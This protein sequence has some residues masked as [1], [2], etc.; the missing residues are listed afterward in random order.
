ME[1]SAD[2]PLLY[3][4]ELIKGYD[5][6]SGSNFIDER[7]L[8]DVKAITSI[9]QYLL[10]ILFPGYSGTRDVTSDNLL[11]VIGDLTCTV[12]SD[13][14]TQISMAFRHNCHEKTCSYT[15]CDEKAAQAVEE[16]MRELPKIR[17]VLKKDVAAA[18][19]GDPAA[20]S[21]EEVVIC[22]PGIKALAI[23]R[24][25]HVLYQ[26]KVPLI[27][28]MMNEIAHAQTGIDIHPGARIGEGLFIDHGT[29]VVIGETTV[30]GSNVKIYQG[31]TL[32]ALSF[33]K[34]Q[35]GN[36][37]RGQKRHPTIQ[38]N[39]TIYAH[40][41]ILGN[42]TIQKSAVIGSNVWLKENVD[43][44]TVVTREEQPINF[45]RVQPS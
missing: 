41:T 38:D 3:I 14:K 29:G 28:R 37:L 35:R 6:S 13:L 44:N 5:T 30:I 17:Q 45:K 21:E 9:L 4:E 18:Y 16:L 39:V 26:K 36:L 27:P 31:V 11:F 25:S 8:P 33:P 23:H 24:L 43:A 15:I 2:N 1:K 32:G 19:S 7:R 10:E 34:D 12:R 42:V 40:A 22:Y 20:V